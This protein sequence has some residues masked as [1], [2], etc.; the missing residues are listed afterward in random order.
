MYIVIATVSLCICIHVGIRFFITAFLIFQLSAT[1]LYLSI[2]VN[3]SDVQ[4]SRST[5]TVANK[6]SHRNSNDT[7]I[8]CTYD[9]DITVFM[10]AFEKV[11]SYFFKEQYQEF[12]M[13]SRECKLLPGGR[14]C[15][16]N[17][18]DESSD[19]IF[20]YG[21]YTERNYKR[22]FDDQIVIVFTMEPENGP[23]CHFPPPDQYDIKISYK[24]NSTVP[25]PFLCEDNAAIRLVNMGQPEVPVGRTKL[26]ASFITNC[27][28]WR[29]NYLK[30]LMKYVHIDQWGKC[31]RNTR[32]NFYR[33]RRGVAHD[34][35]K[36]EF[37]EK[38]PYKFLICFENIIDGDY[39]SE[40]VYHAYLTRTI[41]IYYG[42]KK[43]V[44]DLIPNNSSIIIANDY[45]PKELGELIQRI[46]NNDTLYAQ[47]FA[48]WDLSKMHRLH[49]RYCAEHFICNTCKKVWDVLYRRKC[50]SPY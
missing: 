30:E 44:Y 21:A 36:V 17:H 14:T 49:E 5:K 34:R 41:P 43:A 47:Y 13:K 26:V 23:Y 42:D 1:L 16:F 40:K 6:F 25:K 38:N 9:Q 50:T 22:V 8:E 27:V 15:T 10:D 37:L 46:D 4:S 29:A 18:D 7:D 33:N 12:L 35:L 2:S 24:R 28:K 39:I 19:G 20:Y 11:T 48:D 32:G 31:L 45:T 3:S